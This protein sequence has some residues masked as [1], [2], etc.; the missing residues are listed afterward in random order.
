[1][2]E[3]VHPV[4]L[5]SLGGAVGVPLVRGV[6]SGC[7]YGLVA[8]GLVLIYKSNGIF[9]FAQAEFGS[10]AGFVSLAFLKGLGGFPRVPYPVAIVLGLVAG[11]LVGLVTERLVIHPLFS[12]PRATLLVATAGTA[13]FL[14][15]AQALI[16]GVQVI[17][18]FPP[19]AADT[20]FSAF[21]PVG[22]PH[23][24]TFG[25]TEIDILV[26]VAL[27]VALGAA[28]F[29]TRYGKAILAIS[30]DSTAASI[31]GIDVNKMSALTWTIAGL[32]GGVAGVIYA[33]AKGALTPGY[34]TGI[35]EVGPLVFGFIAAVLGG[36]TSL[37]GAFVG[38]V[39]V[40]IIGSF[41]GAHIPTSVPGGEQIVVA[42][43]LLVVLLVRPTGLLGKET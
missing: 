25:W 8:T 16:L 38:G 21:G 12:A 37:P 42:G 24:Y 9:N 36:M 31:V 27:L 1:V 13:L 15:S 34:M 20:H 6:V 14:I 4:V 30:Q 18:V 43:V 40:G 28:F 23:A 17:H 26:A 41:A 19:V 2:S 5:A 29:R 32:L 39:L 7:V 10:V 11:A 3:L 33:P 22:G 35:G